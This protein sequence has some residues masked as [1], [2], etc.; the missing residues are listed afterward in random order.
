MPPTIR[1]HKDDVDFERRE[2]ARCAPDRD[3]AQDVPSTKEFQRERDSFATTIVNF[4]IV[5]ITF[6][7]AIVRL[8][9]FCFPRCRILRGC[10]ALSFRHTFSSYPL[11]LR[12]FC[13]YGTSASYEKI[14]E[15]IADVL[16]NL[17]TVGYFAS[18]RSSARTSYRN[19]IF[20]QIFFLPPRRPITIGETDCGRLVGPHSLYRIG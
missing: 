2:K 17:H 20:S 18:T 8:A 5:A 1:V 7:C 15:R 13:V 6:S 12:G 11:L 19:T 14:C 9:N 3:F 10:L 4:S 16:Y